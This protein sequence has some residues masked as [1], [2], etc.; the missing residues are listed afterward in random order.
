MFRL[1][2]YPQNTSLCIYKYSKIQKTP[3]P[4]HF[5]CQAFWIRDTQ[6]VLRKPL[7]SNSL[8]FLRADIYFLFTLY[9][10]YGYVLVRLVGQVWL[11][12]SLIPRLQ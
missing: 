4:K 12:L 1:E 2:S 11:L 10:Q 9:K 7:S 8:I 6:L 5:W 3:K